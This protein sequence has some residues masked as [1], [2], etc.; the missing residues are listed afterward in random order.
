MKEWNKNNQFGEGSTNFGLPEGYFQKSAGSIFNKIEWQDEH[1]E[2]PQL[3]KFKQA[4][5]FKVP[6]SYFV[7]KESELEL[8]Y[9]P[10]LV[11]LRNKGVFEVPQHYFEEK[12]IDELTT[13][14]ANDINTLE[15]FATLDSLEKTN[16]FRIPE[17]YFEEKSKAIAQKLQPQSGKIVNLF[18]RR[19]GYAVAAILVVVLGLWIYNIYFTGL[20]AEDCGT[21]ACLDKKDLVKTKTLERLD[22]DELYDL[23]DPSLLEEKI[24]NTDTKNSNSKT[25]DT[26]FKEISVE[27]LLDGI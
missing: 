19:L 3:L 15:T 27:D 24:Q 25:K 22:D 17:N 18:S 6:E 5:N 8:I 2:F 7:R 9:F 26:S 23:V 11:G 10:I 12:G 21:I 4:D 16:S 1:K 20:Q 14:V 13:L